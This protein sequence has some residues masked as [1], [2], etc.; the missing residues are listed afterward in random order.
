MRL[1][2]TT[3]NHVVVTAA[4]TRNQ[5]GTKEATAA[6]PVPIP[7]CRLDIRSSD[8][9]E[10]GRDTIESRGTL[11]VPYLDADDN[12]ITITPFDYFVIDGNQWHVDGDP[13]LKDSHRGPHHYETP[14]VRYRP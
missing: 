3:A 11:F 12:P 2:P 10:D 9:E 5:Y 14:V 4:G 13:N 7:G 1:G 8:E 6:T